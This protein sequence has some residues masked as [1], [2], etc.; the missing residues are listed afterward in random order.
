MEEMFKKEQII[1]KM[2][3]YQRLEEMQVCVGTKSA[4]LFAAVCTDKIPD[5]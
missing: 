3:E 1:P 4:K 2:W 5:N